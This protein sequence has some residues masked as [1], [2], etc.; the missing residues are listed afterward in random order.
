[1]SAGLLVSI[2]I[3]TMP[4]APTDEI[5]WGPV[6]TIPAPPVTCYVGISNA[7]D[8]DR[9]LV[10]SCWVF[11]QAICL[12]RAFVYGRAA[13]TW[14]LE[15]ELAPPAGLGQW[16]GSAVALDGDVAIV[17]AAET[18]QIG[19][20][21][22]FVRD[23]AGVWSLADTLEPWGSLVAR[24][25]GGSL[26][27]DAAHLVVGAPTTATETAADEGAAYVVDRAAAVFTPAAVLHR[28]H[29]HGM[30]GA[31]VAMQGDT[32]VLGAIED[33]MIAPGAAHVYS[34]AGWADGPILRGTEIASTDDASFGDEI[35]LRGDLLLIGAPGMDGPT[36]VD[37]VGAVF[38]F[39]R[40][41][42]GWVEEAA[43]QPITNGGRFGTAIQIADDGT[44]VISAPWRGAV[45]HATYD[46]QTVT[47]LQVVEGPMWAAYFGGDLAID[48]T[49]LIVPDVTA[50]TG[51][52]GQGAIY[53]HELALRLG[54]ACTVADGCHSG[55]CVDGVCC[56]DTCLDGDPG[57][58]IRCDGVG[59]LEPSGRCRTVI[60]PQTCHASTGACDPAEVCD[61]IDWR[62]PQDTGAT[63]GCDLDA[64]ID[65]DAGSPPLAD[66]GP[67]EQSDAGTTAG[68]GP[69]GCCDGGGGGSSAIVLTA[70]ALALL[71]R[72]SI[73]RR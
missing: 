28:S 25:F 48:E 60:E 69:G 33:G 68:P 10:G 38:A 30:A 27:L 71:R 59:T 3:L 36:G 23:G 15:A 11:S 4:A 51:S 26:A 18:N 67:G 14:T 49:Q 56:E 13:G 32:V 62:C 73:V 50:D 40:Q 12:G 63:P 66:A 54:A 42:D 44:L 46:G 35:A 17:S 65:P 29:A 24:S 55:H 39:R 37:N 53:V 16:F 58:C 7:L 64:G 43:I 72:R 47:T 21:H 52:G 31:D 22:V 2:A 8:G 61:G 20:V 70:I 5:V 19:V 9:L 41:G 57:D 45:Y 6:Q 34:G 1:M